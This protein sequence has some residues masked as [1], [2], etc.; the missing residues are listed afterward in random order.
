MKSIE[1]NWIAISVVVGFLAMGISCSVP[2]DTEKPNVLFII[3][4]DLS[5]LSR[6]TAVAIG[7]TEV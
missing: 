2:T 3:A 4:D 5:S 7:A 6:F 1:L